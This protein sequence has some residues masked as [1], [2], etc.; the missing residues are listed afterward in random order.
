MSSISFGGVSTDSS[1]TSKLGTTLF[2]VD[3]DKLV[4]NLV[5][6]RGL[7]ND[8]RQVQIDSNTTKLSALSTFQGLLTTLQS[9]AG[10]L[11]NPVVTSGNA[12]VFDSRQVL[13]TESGTIDAANLFGASITDNA[14]LGNYS[15][16]INR[17]ATADTIT[18]STNF[19]NA[20]TLQPVTADGNLT[21]NG[22]DIALTTGM[23]LNQIR[24]AI[25]GKTTDTGV[26]ASV[27]KVT[28]NSYK[29]VLKATD[30]GD[31]I[32]IADN[33]TGSLMGELGLA[34]SGATDTSLS[35]ELVL[36]GTTLYRADN[37]VTDVIP[38]VSLELYQADAGKPVRISVDNNLTAMSTAIN[39]FVDAY[40]TVIAYIADQ[41]AVTSTGEVGEDQVLYNDAFLTTTYRSLQSLLGEGAQ[42]V[43]VGALKTLRDIGIEI[44]SSNMLTVADTSKLEDALLN[45]LDGV[46][47]LFGF[48]A[49]ETAGLSLVD[50]PGSINSSLYGKEVTVRITATDSNGVPTAGEFEVDGQIVAATISNGFLKG[51][52]GT[53]LEGFTVGYDGGA[54][55]VGNTYTGSFKISQGLADRI[56][57]ML[58]GSLD[59]E[60]ATLQLAKNQLTDTSDRLQTQIDDLNGQ[61]EIY[62]NRLILQFQAAQEAISVLESFQ[63]SIQSQ[64]D[65]WNASN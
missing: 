6:A 46:R 62:R 56:G 18:S 1:G 17:V 59:G 42:G 38:G 29:L 65:S 11:R 50:R 16:T 64:V 30:T 28:D 47:A 61:L 53:V 15:L 8:R 24:D 44:D 23:T 41:R 34:A 10:I 52:S 5:A 2:G 57:A 20:D 32:T 12:D 51:A 35:A 4:E 48:S 26:R 39:N 13:A 7:A 31:A 9:A 55:T 63:S 3:V 14:T 60:N 36:D 49:E 27:V 22:T 37:S 58:D 33:L 45:D 43:D 54:L 40:N 19:A 25:N 21:L